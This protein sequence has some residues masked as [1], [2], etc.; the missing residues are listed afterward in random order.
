MTKTSRSSD[1]PRHIPA[2]RSDRFYV[3]DGEWFY[4]TRENL[5]IGPY[6]NQEKA[7]AG[8]D[9]YLEYMQGEAEGL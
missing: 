4:T 7:L 5:S 9:A 3:E 2:N 1:A 6:P 8:L